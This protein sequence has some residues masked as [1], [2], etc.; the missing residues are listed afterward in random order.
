M[1]EL[2]IRKTNI[3]VWQMIMSIAPVVT[4]S[5]MFGVTEQQAAIVMLKGHEL[6]LGL[7]AAFEFIDV[8]D[9][10]PS[11]KPKGAIA[12]IQQSGQLAGMKITES[13]DDKGNPNACTVWMKRKNGFEFEV[14][15]TMADAKRAQLT[16]GSP[17]ARGK[18]GY[19]NWE[20]Y[21]A[22]MLRW[23]SVG[24]VADIVFPDICGGM[25]RPEELGA[26]VNMLG[27]PL[28]RQDYN[29]PQSLS[30]QSQEIIH[31]TKII[32]L[33][34]KLAEEACQAEKVQKPPPVE[35]PP[36]RVSEPEQA[37]AVL[38]LADLLKKWTAEQIMAANNNSI[39]QTDE[40]VIN[41]AHNLEAG[42]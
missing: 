11:I 29:E 19:G 17:T 30:E 40:D 32:D 9:G 34:A 20:K 18:R 38:T 1:S 10:K 31:G 7:A 24:Y 36:S 23:R 4:A 2:T 21:P 25:L 15:Y 26:Q 8:I 5:R 22:N 6:G 35:R 27:E 37:K 41:V 12:L 28:F 39:P 13:K 16:E 14:T 33:E 3:Q 42:I